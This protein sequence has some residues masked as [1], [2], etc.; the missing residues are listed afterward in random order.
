LLRRTAAALG[1]PARLVPVPV[2][3]LRLGAAALGR[4][5]LWQRLGGT[6]Q[7]SIAHARSQLGWEPP[8]TVDEGLRRAVAGIISRPSSR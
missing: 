5:R 1:A 8:V 6:L 7:C 3:L 2:S 4:R